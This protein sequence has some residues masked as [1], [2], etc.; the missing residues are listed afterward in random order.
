[1]KYTEVTF[2]VV[3]F[4]E[5]ACDVVAAL[6]GGIGFDSFVPVEGG[7][8]GY[9]R[10]DMYDE[11]SLTA[12]MNDFPMPEVSVTFVAQPMEDKDWNEEWEKNFFEPIV[13]GDRCVVHSTFHHDY[14]KAEYDIIINPQ[15]AFGTGHHQTT[16]LMMGYLLD[17]DLK[18]KSILDMGCG[19]GILA[20]LACLRG[21]CHADAIDI[22]QWCVDNTYDNMALNGITNISAFCGDV[23]ALE[24]KGPY[25]VIIANINRNILLADMPGYVACMSKEAR[26]FFSGFYE[27]DLPL[28]REKAESLGLHYVGHH[29]DNEWTAAEFQLLSD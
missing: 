20:I 26:I 23:S 22:D 8:L 24:G 7:V 28:L 13:I 2:S 1:M 3:P 9:V 12:L 14:P 19:T 21:A 15:M 6:T 25:E 18:G 10:T 29:C 5:T 11:T 16:R 17:A 4:S 27:C